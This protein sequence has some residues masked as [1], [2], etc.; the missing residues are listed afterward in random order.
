MNPNTGAVSGEDCYEMI[1]EGPVR[2]AEVQAENFR[3]FLAVPSSCHY[4]S[5][6]YDLIA[7]EPGPIGSL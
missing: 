3:R 4:K 6:M 7:D 2:I 5:H 1:K